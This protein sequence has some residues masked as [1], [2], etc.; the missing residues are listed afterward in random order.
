MSAPKGMVKIF[1][2]GKAGKT[3]VEAEEIGR[4]KAENVLK[5][6]E[7]GLEFYRA[8]GKTKERF[9]VTLDNM[10]GTDEYTKF[11]EDIVALA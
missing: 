9:C 7:I 2:G 10:R 4:I 5:A 6:V 1:V 11:V 3:I 8:H